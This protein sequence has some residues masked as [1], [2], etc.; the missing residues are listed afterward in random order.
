LGGTGKESGTSSGGSGAGD[1]GGGLSASAAET[2]TTVAVA[3]TPIRRIVTPRFIPPRA[4]R[5][6]TAQLDRRR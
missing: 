6:R 1:G 2:R 5:L 4:P 3:A